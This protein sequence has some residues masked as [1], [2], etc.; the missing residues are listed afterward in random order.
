MSILTPNWTTPD[1]VRAFYTTRE[2]GRSVDGYAS[3][4]LAKHV[5]DNPDNV[6]YHRR[7][8]PHRQ[9]TQWLDQVHGGDCVE[10]DEN[11]PPDELIQADAAVTSLKERVCIVMTADCVPVLVCD[12]GG[13]RVA[14]IHAGWRGLASGVVQNTLQRMAVPMAQLTLWIGPHIRQPH[15]EVGE[16]V[17]QAFGNYP[18][19]FL[20]SVR[21]GKHLFSMTQVIHTIC[22]EMG[23]SQ[24]VDSNL[25]S[26]ANAQ[27]FYSH[28][29]SSHQHNLPTGRMACGIYL[30]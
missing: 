6:D 4:N 13:K 23:I 8:L 25:C 14:A 27:L 22:H 17:K 18:Q 11:Q 26:Y 10:L 9:T 7:Q 24:I 2:G 16:Q 5:L 21:A 28:R 3:F 20:P 29:R 15:F 19:A 12:A 30:R 1:S